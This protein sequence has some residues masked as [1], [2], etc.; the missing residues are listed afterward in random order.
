MTLIELLI[1]V[2]IVGILAAIAIPGYQSY[3]MSANR[4]DAT[5]S[6]TLDAQALE[7]CYSQT[8][9]Y[10]GCATAPAGAAQSHQGFYTITIA[11]PIATSYTI[12]AVP[13]KAPQTGD[14]ACQQFTL[15]SAG[16]QGATNSAG[17]ANTQTCWGST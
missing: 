11:V 5:Q 4:T 9:T 7:R 1:A 17:A 13:A 10:A 16:Q 8:F 15:N 6:M 12:T 14:S 3:T 2:A